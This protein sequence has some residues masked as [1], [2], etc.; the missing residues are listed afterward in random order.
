MVEGEQHVIDRR[1]VSHGS[2]PRLDERPKPSSHETMR[3]STPC[4][5]PKSLLQKRKSPDL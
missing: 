1:T 4:A 3:A 2:K 5:E